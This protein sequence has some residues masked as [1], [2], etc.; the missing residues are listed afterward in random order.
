MLP[1]EAM[2]ETHFQLVVIR[3]IEGAENLGVVSGGGSQHMLLNK[4][5]NALQKW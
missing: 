3:F 1:A 5:P 4:P 2:L